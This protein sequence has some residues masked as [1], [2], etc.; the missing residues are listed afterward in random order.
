M[1]IVHEVQHSIPIVGS[2][3][4]AFIFRLSYVN[5]AVLFV[6]LARVTD[7]KATDPKTKK[8]VKAYSL[9]M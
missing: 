3:Y 4:L 5:N 9:R 7:L 1:A 8:L 6:A 2:E